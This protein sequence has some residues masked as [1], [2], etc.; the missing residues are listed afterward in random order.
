M[1]SGTSQVLNSVHFSSPV[2]G[3][4]V[5]NAG[6]ILRYNG[7][8]GL[9]INS[10]NAITDFNFYPNP[11]KDYVIINSMVNS[12]SIKLFNPLGELIYEGITSEEVKIDISNYPSG[13]YFAEWRTSDKVV[14][15]KFVKE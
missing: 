8:A 9:G 10:P 11:A 6:T 4:A 12:A 2:D 7:S 5:G 1:M 15:K 3:W 14:V 13:V